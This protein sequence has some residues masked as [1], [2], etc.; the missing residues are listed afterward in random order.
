V[1]LTAAGWQLVGVRFQSGFWRFRRP[2]EH[3]GQ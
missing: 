2:K 1:E 3:L